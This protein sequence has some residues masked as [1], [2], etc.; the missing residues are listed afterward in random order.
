MKVAP[1]SPGPGKR[2]SG[3]RANA[4][5]N[6]Q[7]KKT[8]TTER[9]LSQCG[10]CNPVSAR[11]RNAEADRRTCRRPQTSQPF[12]ASLSSTR[13]HPAGVISGKDHGTDAEMGR[14]KPLTSSGCSGEAV[15]LH[16][17]YGLL[18]RCRRQLLSGGRQSR[19]ATAAERFQWA[20]GVKRGGQCQ[21]ADRFRRRP[22]E[23]KICA[24]ML[25]WYFTGWPR[26]R[27]DAAAD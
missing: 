14:V 7:A 22:S 25:P 23:K 27:R 20:G 19:S 11:S 12:T 18:R 9:T 1:T 16:A 13:L 15:W 3:T 8:R 17:T 6:H 26:R 10:P 4:W 5:T 21:R 24:T 2:T